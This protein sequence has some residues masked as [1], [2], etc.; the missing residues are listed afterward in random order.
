VQLA[1][2]NLAW[3]RYPL[4][5]PRMAPMR[6]EIDRINRLG[7][8]SPGFVWRFETPEGDATAVRVLDDPT[9]LFN[10]TIWHS[11]EDLRRYVYRTEHVDFFRRRREWFVPPPKPPLALWWIA[12]GARPDVEESLRR[13]D[14]LWRLG[15]TPEAF[16]LAWAFDAEGRAE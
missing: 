7:D 3:M 15:P 13:L 10:L 6:D 12:A 9:I 2:T 11:V 14:L 16:T 4:E 8:D 1:Q 5:D